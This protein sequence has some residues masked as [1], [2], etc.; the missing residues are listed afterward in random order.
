M[1]PKLY[2]AA[3]EGDVMYL[4]AR[5][6]RMKRTEEEDLEAG[7]LR[8]NRTEEDDN[9]YGRS[10]EYLLDRTQHGNN[11]ILHIAARSG[12]DLF[13]AVALQFVPVLSNQV[14]SQ[15]DTPLL[16]AARFGRLKVVETITK[17]QFKFQI[18]RDMAAAT[19]T[20]IR[21]YTVVAAVAAVIVVV[22]GMKKKG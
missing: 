21:T 9:R 5:I 4:A 17:P 10:E 7:I 13:V 19:T 2:K 6:V 3:K 16:A 8:V 15:G 11:N 22:K 18:R 14:N 20:L 12:R 1:D